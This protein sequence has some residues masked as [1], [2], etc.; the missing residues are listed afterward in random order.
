MYILYFKHLQL[1]SI[2]S[3]KKKEKKEKLIPLFC[4][5]S[6]LPPSLSPLPGKCDCPFM[7]PAGSANTNRAPPP[8]FQL[9]HKLRGKERAVRYGTFVWWRI[10]CIRACLALV[11]LY[12]YAAGTLL[13]LLQYHE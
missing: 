6:L 9:C 2:E 1:D 13:V 12:R 7:N 8:F 4:L 11:V 3:E 10:C 5:P